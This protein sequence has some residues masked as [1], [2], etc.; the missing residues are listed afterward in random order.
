MDHSRA[1]SL[2]RVPPLNQSH[3]HHVATAPNI[4]GSRDFTPLTPV[5]RIQIGGNNGTDRPLDRPTLVR[6]NRTSLHNL[7]DQQQQQQP[8]M[9]QMQ[10]QQLQQNQ[11][12][13]QQPEPFVQ[14]YHNQPPP[15]SHMRPTRMSQPDLSRSSYV[16]PSHQQQQQQQPEYYQQQPAN[17]TPEKETFEV[18]PMNA[19][20]PCGIEMNDFLPKKFHDSL[21]F[22]Q[23]MESHCGPQKPVSRFSAYSRYQDQDGLSE[24]EV[25]SSLLK[26]HES[27]MSVL[28]RRGRNIEIIHKLWHNKDA[29]AGMSC[30]AFKRFMYLF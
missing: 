17:S 1:Q 30:E 29:K 19:D 22:A 14:F 21:S 23:V 18:I 3:L 10:P 20:K 25:T 26:G 24:S 11:Q 15:P 13:Q 9:A 4:A 8:T 5:S 27:M 28:S 16:T 7:S 6:P 12:H 2:N